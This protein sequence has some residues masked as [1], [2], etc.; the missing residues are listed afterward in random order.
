MIILL[1]HCWSLGGERCLCDYMHGEMMP[2]FNEQLFVMSWTM[3]STFSV[4]H[5]NKLLH[6]KY[7]ICEIYN[8]DYRL[9]IGIARGWQRGQ[10]SPGAISSAKR[11][12]L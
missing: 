12:L 9:T 11:V 2:R 8:V 4:E 3:K 1:P 7:Q 5:V 10:L 6:I